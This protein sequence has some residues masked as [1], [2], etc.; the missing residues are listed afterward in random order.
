[1]KNRIILF[2]FW[3]ADYLNIINWNQGYGAVAAG[4]KVHID[5]KSP[6]PSQV[7]CYSAVPNGI[8][9]VKEATL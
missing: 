8:P 9:E 1:M 2:V 4:N 5:A 3:P 6:C 7:A